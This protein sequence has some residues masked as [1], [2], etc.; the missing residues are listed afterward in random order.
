MKNRFIEN[1]D[2][3]TEISLRNG[4]DIEISS[5]IFV[6]EAGIT[7]WSEEK[8]EFDRAYVKWLKNEFKGEI[9]D[10]I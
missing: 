4:L 9:A 6:K 10:Y 1:Y 7:D 5:I 8:E 2:K 3:I